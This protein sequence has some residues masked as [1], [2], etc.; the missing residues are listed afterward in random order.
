MSIIT[1]AT[2]KGGAGKTTLARL[3]LG[4]TAQ[5]GLTP[6][7]IDADFN[8]TLTDWATTFAKPPL[9]VQH[10]LDE[11]KIVPLVSE[12]H[13]AHDLVV[14]DTAGAA[15]QSTIFAIGCADLVLVPIAQ[16]SAD[17]IEGI[18]TVNLVKSASQMMGKE[19]PRTVS[20]VRSCAT[21]PMPAMKGASSAASNPMASGRRWSSPSLT[22]ACAA[23]SRSPPLCRATRSTA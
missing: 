18:K 7:A 6:A 17:V 11:T 10:E 12:L 9:T 4:R 15:S 20:R 1:V 16:S 14:I 2:T 23:R 22:F 19:I 5:M 3:I 21:S 13:E 8:R